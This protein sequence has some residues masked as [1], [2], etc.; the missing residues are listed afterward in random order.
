[1]LALRQGAPSSFPRECLS[2]D[3]ACFLAALLKQKPIAISTLWYTLD[4]LIHVAVLAGEE[5]LSDQN[6]PKPSA[7][8]QTYFLNLYMPGILEL[9][10]EHLY[11]EPR[12]VLRE[13]IRNAH[14][15]CQPRLAENR[16]LPKDY[17]PR[18]DIDIEPH[19]RRLTARDNGSCFDRAGD[20]WLLSGGYTRE[21]R[22]RVQFD[23]REESLLL[24]GCLGWGSVYLLGG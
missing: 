23:V 19:L 8:R 21:L 5:A 18:I 7:K 17:Q 24:I 3:S 2:C 15:S 12:A 22:E 6:I 1:M 11:A 20:S 13:L 16:H 10:D 14:D 4:Q 9:L